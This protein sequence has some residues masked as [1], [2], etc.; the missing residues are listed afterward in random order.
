MTQ[1]QHELK[2]RAPRS[3]IFEAL[4]D[5]AALER[6][7]GAKVKE[8]EHEWRFEYPDATVF[9]W[10]VTES[11][12][13]RVTWQCVEGPAQAPGKEA[14]FSL[15]EMGDK[16]TLVEFAHTGWQGTGGNHRKCNTR[17]A[18]LLHRLQQEVEAPAV[19]KD[20]TRRRP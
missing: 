17:W 18:I 9:R 8:T 10:K 1:I 4:T 5:R 11:N 20:K 15:S 3:R 6:W 12:P 19:S 7:Q 13:A 2:I 14:S 16:R